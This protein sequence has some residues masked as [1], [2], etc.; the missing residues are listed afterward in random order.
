MNSKITALL[1]ALVS[2]TFSVAAKNPTPFA[3]VASSKT[4]VYN[5][6]YTAAEPGKVKV[7]ILN[8]ESQLVFTEVLNNV[9]SFKRPYNFSQLSEG[10][11]TI[12]VEDKNGKHVDQVNYT[13]NKVQSFISVVEAANAENKYVL[14]VTNNGSEEVLVKIF[15]GTTLLH[16][17]SLKVTGNFGLVYNLTKIK[18]PE[19]ITFEVT[20]GNGQTHVINF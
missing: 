9:S 5:I 11:Y 15:N 2:I 16:S 7:S 17:Q 3:V 12:V 20:T 10:Q 4:S 6:Y 18:S 8:S 13:M 19:T 14:N 1:F